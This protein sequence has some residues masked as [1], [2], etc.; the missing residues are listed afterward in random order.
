MIIITILHNSIL[1][2]VLGA[3]SRFNSLVD[4]LGKQEY[5]VLNLIGKLWIFD[6]KE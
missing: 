3:E 6:V 2:Y 5:N 1:N 4:L